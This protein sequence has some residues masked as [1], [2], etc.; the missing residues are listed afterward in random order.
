MAGL[1]WTSFSARR[2]ATIVVLAC[3]KLAWSLELYLQRYRRTLF[4]IGLVDVK[5]SRG[6][7][8]TGEGQGQGQARG[9]VKRGGGRG[10]AGEDETTG[11]GLTLSGESR[12]MAA[13]ARL[14]QKQHKRAELFM[15][16][17][18]R[19]TGGA[20]PCWVSFSFGRMFFLQVE[21]GDQI[22]RR[23]CCNAELI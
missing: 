14:V 12:R 11:T 20:C 10:R 22:G 19:V 15:A 6:M 9:A 3:H 7:L 21:A 17:W 8:I 16:G 1:N 18:Q 4:S 23:L 5:R 2:C 13:N